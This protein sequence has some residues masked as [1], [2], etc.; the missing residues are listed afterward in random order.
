MEGTRVS[1]TPDGGNYQL[2]GRHGRG[3]KKKA[4]YRIEVASKQSVNVGFFPYR[5]LRLP[6]C[7]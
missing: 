3:W 5:D 6:I 4:R 1:V 7:F 2:G